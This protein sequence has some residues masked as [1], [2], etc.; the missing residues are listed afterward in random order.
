MQ[1]MLAIQPCASWQQEILMQPYSTCFEYPSKLLA[2]LFR[3]FAWLWWNNLNTIFRY[4]IEHFIM[5][6]HFIMF[7]YVL[8]SQC[9]NTKNKYEMNRN[10]F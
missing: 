7:L 4:V 8:Y 5:F 6:Y 9:Y 1:E 3:K 2:T 10:Q